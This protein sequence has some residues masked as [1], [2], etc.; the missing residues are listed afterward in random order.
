M[1]LVDLFPL[2]AAV[3]FDERTKQEISELSR[4]AEAALSEVELEL[5]ADGARRCDFI[6]IDP[7]HPDLSIV[8]R[9]GL[10]HRVIDVVKRYSGFAHT[11]YRPQGIEDSLLFTTVCDSE[12]SLNTIEQAYRSGD[13]A[14][15]GRL[16]GYPDCDIKHFV[17]WWGKH[18]DL[19]YPTAMNSARDG[20][21]VY[22]DPR[23]NVMLRYIGI[24]VIFHFPC[25]FQCPNAIAFAERILE[26]LRRRS[27]QMT[28]RL[29]SVLSKPLVFSQVN[30][31]IQV[32]VFE[33]ESFREPLF[34]VVQS[35]YSDDEY[36]IKMVPRW[37]G[38]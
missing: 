14:T 31:I 13:H 2:S 18:L 29:L 11:H 22:F 20:D 12:D 35:G 8:Y 23:L 4:W 17:A 32:E 25:S 34:I 30:G 3:F 19:V 15:I 16:L 6:H 37:E 7:L 21:V 36:R 10:K 28:E 26:K 24:R 38:V 9:L 1:P 33:D 5:I 27:P